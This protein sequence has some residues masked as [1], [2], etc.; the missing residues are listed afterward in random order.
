[1]GPSNFFFR[2]IRDKLV[3]FVIPR[4]GF[5]K[6]NFCHFYPHLFL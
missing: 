5:E 2:E 1:M 4:E 6:S 3:E